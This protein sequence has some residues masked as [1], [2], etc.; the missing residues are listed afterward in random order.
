MR[1]WITHV[2][3]RFVDVQ[4]ASRSEITSLDAGLRMDGLPAHQFRECVLETLSSKPAN[5][6]LERHK[7][8]R[9]IQSHSHC[10]NCVF[11]P[12]DNVPPNIP[13]SSHSTQLY[14]FAD[15]AAVIQMINKG[16]SANLRHV[17]RTH[18]VNLDC[19]FERVSLDHAILIKHV[20]TN[21]QLAD[22]LTKDMFTTMQWHSLLHLWQIR[23]Q[24]ESNEVRSFSRKPFS[25]SAL[26]K[27][28]SNVS[29]DY[30]NREC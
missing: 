9:V 8:E 22:I 14:L 30:T 13:N 3:S 23:Q 5:G 15:N 25:C 2:C 11:E 12:I 28:P 18:R 19:L 7:R 10:D 27:P 29:G 1:I 17:T 26:A 6:H 4:E 16:R 21:D 20:R 24:C